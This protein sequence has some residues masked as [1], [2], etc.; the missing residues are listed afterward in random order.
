MYLM[1]LTDEKTILMTISAYATCPHTNITYTN[2]PLQQAARQLPF[3]SWYMYKRQIHYLDIDKAC[4]LW[5]VNYYIGVAIKLRGVMLK[6][7]EVNWRYN[8]YHHNVL[9]CSVTGPF[10]QLLHK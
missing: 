2:L 9:S 3:I 8:A 1:T 10:K 5:F 4:L 7:E 6:S